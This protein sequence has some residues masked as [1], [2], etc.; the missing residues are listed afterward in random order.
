MISPNSAVET[1]ALVR[2]SLQSGEATKLLSIG[3]DGLF[4]LLLQFAI[5]FKVPL[6]IAP[7]GTG[8]DFPKLSVRVKDELVAFGSPAAIEV[9][10]NGV[11]NGGKHLKPFEVDKLVEER[12]EEII[13]F[14]SRNSFEAKIGKFKNAIVPDIESTRD[15]IKE[16]EINER[17][18]IF[19]ALFFD[20]L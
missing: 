18:L 10:E 13:F 5:E 16:I 2:Q 19:Y 12:G 14:D 1:K 9:D 7:G 3:G 15:F 4:H 6:A 17:L 8:N 20:G 11:I